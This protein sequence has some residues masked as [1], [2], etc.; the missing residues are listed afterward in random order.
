MTDQPHGSGVETPLFRS[1]VRD[2]RAGAGLTQLGLAERLGVKQPAVSAWESGKAYPTAGVLLGLA[3]LL[4]L[5]VKML[6]EQIVAEQ[7]AEAVPA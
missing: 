7:D 2:A 6:L 3:E 5:D 4:E 1:T